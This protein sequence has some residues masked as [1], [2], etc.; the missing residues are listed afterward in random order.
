MGDVLSQN[1]SRHGPRNI[2]LQL[3]I[4]ARSLCYA[5]RLCNNSVAGDLELMTT[6]IMI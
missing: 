2:Y 6:M 5:G 3:I 4:L 1:S